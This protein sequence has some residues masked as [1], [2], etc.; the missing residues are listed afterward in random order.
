M[1]TGKITLLDPATWDD[2]NDRS[3]IEACRKKLEAKMI[4]ALC[5]SSARQTY[6]HWRVFA[7]GDHGVCITFKGKELLEATNGSD[8]LEFR[9]IQYKSASALE[10]E[11]PLSADT[12]KFTKHLRYSDEKEW[13]LTYTDKVGIS[14]NP[15]ILFDTKVVARVTISPWLAKP[16]VDTF[17]SVIRELP[18]GKKLDIRRSTLV[19]LQ[20][21]KEMAVRST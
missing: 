11:L 3:F 7:P 1:H 21:W 12:L 9:P 4:Y 6:H 20:S 19:D 2:Q 16:L 18:G 10:N 8:E 17:K 5:F 13:R 14:S 15:S